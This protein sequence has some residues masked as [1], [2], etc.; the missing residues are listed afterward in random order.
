MTIFVF[1][2]HFYSQSDVF[3]L[4]EVFS[5]PGIIV[6]FENG[7]GSFQTFL[8]YRFETNQRSALCSRQAVMER[9]SWTGLNKILG[10]VPHNK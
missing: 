10:V 6:F 1:S 2:S 3:K 7:L 9:S 8:Y 4:Q 5:E